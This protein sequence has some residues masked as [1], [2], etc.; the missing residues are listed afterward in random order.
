[1]SCLGTFRTPAAD[2][3]PIVHQHPQRPTNIGIAGYPEGHPLIDSRTLTDTL[4]RKSALATYITT[5]L[6][7]D[8][9]ALLTWLGE[10]R[11]RGVALP[12]RVGLPGVVDRRRLVEISMRIGVGPSLGFLRK[13]RGLRSLLGRSRVTPDRL[14]DALLPGLE[15]RPELNVTGFHYYTFNQ[16][17][18]T[19]K[20]ER[21]KREPV[22]PEQ[23]I[24]T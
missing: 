20:W 4:E 22:L 6:C 7:F 24:T 3:L 19:W 14:Y 9:E 1:V 5:Q 10:T 13:Q 15:D 12:V 18:D 23:A 11:E 21:E 8:A 17:V 16:L 2:L